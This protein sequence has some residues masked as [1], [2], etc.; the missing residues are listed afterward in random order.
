MSF[1]DK[2]RVH[3]D[4]FPA[5]SSALRAGK[6]VRVA[7]VISVLASVFLLLLLGSVFAHDVDKPALIMPLA[8]KSLV[9]DLAAPG[10]RLVAAG[11]RGHVLVSEDEAQSWQQEEIPTRRML[12]ALFFRDELHGWAVGHGSDILATE[13]G[14]KSWKLLN[15]TPEEER[16][17]FDI[18][19]SDSYGFAIG[20][21]AKFM[22]TTDGGKT[23]QPGE[24]VI[25]KRAESAEPA[26]HAEEAEDVEN[27]EAAEEDLPFDFHLNRIGR[28]ADGIFYIAA[29]AGY[30]FRS[31]DGGH[32]WQGLPSPYNG[33]FFGI[34]PLGGDSLLVY[35][36]RG[37]AFRSEDSGQT[38][39]RIE[40]GTTALLT[41]AVK[42]AG[43]GVVITGMAGVILVSTDS[44]RSFTLRRPDRISLT[45]VCEIADDTLLFAGERGFKSYKF[46][47]LIKP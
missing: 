11:W 8:A 9:L 30:I 45:A 46:T 18:Y 26:A 19:V 35:G 28:S 42:L 16:P 27:A 41:D 24:F 12:T 1:V 3:N 6:A 36:L 29:E 13:D 25:R 40:T 4:E 37:H 10:P 38:W 33:S 14:G 32:T 31:D 15:S 43:G 47:E 23:W 17:L 44:G 22:T 21:Y 34:L 39:A 5:V 20:A 2:K 7:G